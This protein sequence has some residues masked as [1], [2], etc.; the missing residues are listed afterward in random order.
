MRRI[1]E[2]QTCVRLLVVN[3]LMVHVWRGP[4]RAWRPLV[5]D[6]IDCLRL[7]MKQ[8]ALA[9]VRLAA[10]KRRLRAREENLEAVSK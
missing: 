3:T 5:P 10:I 7:V 4:A 1:A 6:V 8:P 2:A 9:E